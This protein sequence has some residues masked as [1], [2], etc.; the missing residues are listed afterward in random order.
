M[1]EESIRLRVFAAAKTALQQSRRE[2]EE[3]ERAE[4]KERFNRVR[5]HFE[6]L[7]N[8]PLSPENGEWVEV[9]GGL[10]HKG[11]KWVW[12][13]KDEQ[14]KA[15]LEFGVYPSYQGINAVFRPILTC[16]GCGVEYSASF[17]RSRAEL[18]QILE[19]TQLCQSC[20]TNSVPF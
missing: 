10:E 14:G 16:T 4:A 20:L 15:F 3:Q 12:R 13:V 8:T 19:D 5:Y 18:G 17:A 7:F 6:Y 9:D 11:L 2:K 1:T